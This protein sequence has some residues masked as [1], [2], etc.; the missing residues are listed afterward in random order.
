MQGYTYQ[1]RRNFLEKPYCIVIN[2]LTF[3]LMDIR[4]IPDLSPID[5][6][7]Y[8]TGKN[9]KQISK[10]NFM[11]FT[12]LDLSRERQ[13]L[14]ELTGI[15]NYS[16]YY[17]AN[18]ISRVAPDLRVYLADGK[19]RKID[20]IVEKEKKLPKAVFITAMSSSFPT[21][22]ALSIA[23]NYGDIPVVLGGI[24]VSATPEDVDIF[25]RSHVPRPDM[26]SVVKG[27][28][29]SRVVREVLD[30]IDEGTQKSLY[31]GYET[32]EDGV[33]G[34]EN[35]VHM[36]E[37]KSIFFKKLPLVGNFIMDIAKINVT[38]PFLGC[39]YSCNFCSISTLPRNQRRFV[40]RSADDFLAELYSHQKNGPNMKNRNFF[41]LPDNLMLGG[42]RLEEILD[43]IIDSDLKINYGAQV[44]IDVAKD[45]K[46]LKKLRLSGASHFFI[47]LESLDIRN[48][49]Y[50]GKNSVKDIRKS[51]KSVWDYY[52]EQVKKIT[53]AGI[54]IH[55]AFIFGLPYDYFHS[56]N[57]HSGRD[58]A[59]FCI[60][61]KIG[62]QPTALND[63]PGS[64]LFQESQEKGLHVYGK[65]GTMDYL[66]AL[67]ISDLSEINR[68]V[69]DSLYG[70]P[71][72]VAYMSYDTVCRVASNRAAVRNSLFMAKKAWDS[73]TINGYMNKKDRVFDSLS[74]IAFQLAAS[75]YRDIGE[76]V[77]YSANGIRGS[78]ERLY[79]MEENP[80]IKSMFREYV[81]RFRDQESAKGIS[82]ESAQDAFSQAV[83]HQ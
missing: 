22:A 1:K 64:K 53:D 74:A 48:L 12:N 23:L 4:G 15:E 61:H 19:R 26:I 41:F 43:K 20:W 55:G 76:A 35:L 72:A 18:Q 60:S 37:M 2:P 69:P 83:L 28:G 6:I 32:I 8:L 75:A 77:V 24:H 66:C 57:N 58:V 42:K 7:S 63:L 44:S 5:L 10:S 40:T 3:G 17:I 21:M 67:C 39:P 51:G 71:L 46:L 49:E 62:L 47:G 27:P 68:Q 16:V 50:I 9:A 59:R 80:K 79:E 34:H 14:M 54:S 70:S 25:I 30:D 81:N 52:S 45:E 82:G 11:D 33:W 78:F 65:Q 73:P 31:Q 29:D 36:P 38:T 13:G 56:L